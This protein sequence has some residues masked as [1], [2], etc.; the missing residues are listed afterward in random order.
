VNPEI[1]VVVNTYNTPRALALVLAALRRQTFNAFELIIADDGSGDDTREVIG[2]FSKS[3]DFQI[4]HVWHPDKGFR[5]CTILNKAVLAASGEYIVFLGGDCIPSKSC[6]EV[7][8][9]AARPGHYVVGGKVNLD[10]KTSDQLTE[11]K[12]EQGFADRVGW[13]W[14]YTGK[15][16]RLFVSKIPLLRDIL[17]RTGKDLTW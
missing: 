11:Q 8:R 13:H 6:I 7:H 2:D 9:Q 15:R 1:S 14:L 4:T 5:L 12:I 10:R 16:R 17:N 3:N